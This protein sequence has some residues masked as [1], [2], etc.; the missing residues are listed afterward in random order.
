MRNGFARR[1]TVKL[2]CRGMPVRPTEPTL[3]QFQ[4]KSAWLRLVTWPKFGQVR[5]TKRFQIGY[6]L[7]IGFGLFLDL[8]VLEIRSK[9]TETSECVDFPE[10]SRSGPF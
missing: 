6:A 9:T 5:H 4:V 7:G 1:G 2:A 8:R 10:I 3:S